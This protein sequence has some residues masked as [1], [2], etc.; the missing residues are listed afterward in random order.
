MKRFF[1]SLIASIIILSISTSMAF[2]DVKS[3]DLLDIVSE[4][5]AKIDICVEEAQNEAIGADS[6][7]LDKIINKLIKDTNKIVSKTVK[8]VEKLG[9]TVELEYY[10]VEVGGRTVTIDPMTVH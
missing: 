8:E 7:E 3:T 1:N 10:D 2:A 9:H 4:A 5:N 6:K